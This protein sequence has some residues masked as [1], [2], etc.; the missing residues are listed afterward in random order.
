MKKYH[1]NSPLDGKAYEEITDIRKK[2]ADKGIHRNKRFH[3]RFH[4]SNG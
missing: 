2:L 3:H 4:H 1:K